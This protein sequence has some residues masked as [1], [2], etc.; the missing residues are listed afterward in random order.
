MYGTSG[1]LSEDRGPCRVTHTVETMIP[2]K[3]T[4]RKLSSGKREGILEVASLFLGAIQ[5]ICI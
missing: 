1:W 5:Y 2:T 4:P 3:S